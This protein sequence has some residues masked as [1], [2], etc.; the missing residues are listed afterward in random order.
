M[1]VLL[2]ESETHPF[3][4]NFM[5]FKVFSLNNNFQMNHVTSRVGGSKIDCS[6]ITPNALGRNILLE[7]FLS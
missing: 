2:D 6:D 4:G 7:V 3:K 5:V 1:C